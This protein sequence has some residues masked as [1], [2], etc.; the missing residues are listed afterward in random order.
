MGFS[1]LAMAMLKLKMGAAPA[2]E[3]VAPLGYSVGFLIAVLG[4]Q[5]LFTET[6][7]TASLPIL[8]QPTWRGIVRLVRMWNMV[9][10]ANLVGT[11]VFA[12]L[13]SRPGFLSEEASHV[14][15]ET[16]QGAFSRWLRRRFPAR[17]VFGLADRARSSGCCRPRRSAAPFV[18]AALT[19]VVALAGFPHIIAGST[20]AAYAVFNG[21][22]DWGDYFGASCRRPCSA[23]PSAAPR[24]PR[25]STMRPS[26]TTWRRARRRND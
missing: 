26:R 4:K 25:C 6:T 20:E 22:A 13:V 21:G 3:A 11:I 24:S 15:L 5:Q 1:F 12:W 18:I 7:L 23:T 10:F 19:Y 2:A 8:H 9:L 14:F 16:A 17:D